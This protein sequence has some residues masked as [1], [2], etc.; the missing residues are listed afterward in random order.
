MPNVVHYSDEQYAMHLLWT[1]WL[2][3]EQT[4]ALWQM[5][6]Q[7]ALANGYPGAPLSSRRWQSPTGPSA[8]PVPSPETSAVVHAPPA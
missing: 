3:D 7:M 1:G 6:E 5:V 4:A 8:P 2:T